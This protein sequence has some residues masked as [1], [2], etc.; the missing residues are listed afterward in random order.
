M[1]SQNV[2]VSRSGNGWLISAVGRLDA[3]F[4][5]V[6]T[7]FE[8]TYGNDWQ[9]QLLAIEGRLRG[10]S[11]ALGTS[12]GLT[13]ATNDFV[14]N[15]ERGSNTHQ[16]PPR[17][18]ILPNSFFGAYEALAIRLGTAATGT[19]IPAYVPPDAEATAVVD[20]LTTRRI[21]TPEGAVDIREFALTLTGPA[22]PIPLEVWVDARQRLARIVLPLASVVVIRD[23]LASVMV[24]EDPVRNRGDEPA[25]IPANGFS[26]GATITRPASQATRAAAV[27][28]V[29]SAGPQG[30]EYMTYGIPV[31]G[32]MAGT[33]AEAGYLV[34]RYD[35]R[36]TGQSGGRTE[37]IGL[38][39][40][41]EDA[42]AV[43]TWLRKREDVDPNRIVLVGYAEGAPIAL[44]AAAREKR[45]RGVTLIGAAG[46]SGRDVAIEQQQLLLAR[47]AIPESDKAERRGLQTRLI[48]AALTGRGLDQL[49]PD[50]RRDVASPWFRS[51]LL[52]DPAVTMK[53]VNQPILVVHGALD[54]EVPR[55]HA[56]R[57]ESLSSLRKVPAGYTRKVVAAGVN[58]LLVAASTGEMD[59]YATLQA[60]TVS[61]EVTSALLL[62]LPGV[63]TNR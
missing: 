56:D 52:F 44:I 60:R 6:T 36:G 53:K 55:A 30:R 32:Q 58:H 12:F 54:T 1:G 50:L 26:L 62:W 11:I 2:T 37:T 10:Q 14:Q 34:V 7:K 3:P 27:V 22:G 46:T 24:R 21:L 8:M 15:G 59:E 19:R 39:E 29:A 25:F 45:V 13:T 17:A 28:F 33:L 47:L 43:V 41:A 42:I 16:I 40:Y 23:D 9:P 5:L 4:D 18:V 57:L 49:P 61:P 20:R 51:W 48:D 35:G 31:F 38:D 63:W